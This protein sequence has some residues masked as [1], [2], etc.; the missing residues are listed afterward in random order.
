M[1]NKH[2]VQ[3]LQALTIQTTA[4]EERDPSYF[5]NSGSTSDFSKFVVSDCPH[6]EKVH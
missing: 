3:R 6:E 1:I 4:G 2:F 5:S